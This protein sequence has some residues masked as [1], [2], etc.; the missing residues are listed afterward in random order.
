MRT[1]IA[2][3]VFL[4]STAAAALPGVGGP[5]PP[6][7]PDSACPLPGVWTWQYGGIGVLAGWGWVCVYPPHPFST[8]G[9]TRAN[10]YITHVVYAV[11]ATSSSVSYSN[12]NT[13]G[14]TLKLTNSWT[15]EL[16]V[17]AKQGA[18]II[19]ATGWLD[20]TFAN[21]WG[22]TDIQEADVEVDN[23]ST[24]KKVGLADEIDH[25]EDEIWFLASP[26][27]VLSDTPSSVYGPETIVWN[28]AGDTA[29][30]TYYLKVGELK[31][32]LPIDPG[33]WTFLTANNITSADFPEMLKADPFV[34]G[35]APNTPMD[36]A[37]FELIGE[38]PFVPVTG[39]N[40]SPVTQSYKVTNK[41]T[42]SDEQQS[43]V[44]YQT[45]IEGGASISF[46]AAG[47]WSVK[48]K[49][50]VIAASSLKLAKE[51]DS[52]VDVQIGQPAFGYAGPTVLR[53]YQDK[54]WKTIVLTLDWF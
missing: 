20:L 27:V 30:T 8:T 38:M 48:N 44:Q 28:Y 4:V 21:T 25:D 1:H 10:Y 14:S 6:K 33:V 35:L 17:E 53:G 47:S 31:G 50:T 40:D 45:T 29:T 13:L 52:E 41:V 22:S 11:P 3:L 46:I 5:P 19:V 12:T 49:L 39:P 51:D 37:R 42:N 9:S 32:T 54:I 43:Q 2:A 7:P 18:N 36:P 15:N 24:Y 23:E 16:T 26:L 34:D